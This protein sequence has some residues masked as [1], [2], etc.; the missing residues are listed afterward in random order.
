MTTFF[1]GYQRV[2]LIMLQLVTRNSGKMHQQKRSRF[3]R[4]WL[5]R[6]LIA[7]L[8][9]K[10]LDIRTYVL[11]AL[12]KVGDE[13]AL[14]VIL[15]AAKDSNSTI[16]RYAVSALADMGDIRATDT[17]I[18]ALGDS[19]TDIRVEAVMALGK[20]RDKRA[21]SVLIALLDDA[22]MSVRAQAV[23]SLGHIGSE[24]ALPLLN[25]M[26][27]NESGE[28]MRRYISEAIREIEGGYCS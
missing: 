2:D 17:L 16:R 20:L 18:E 26:M 13:S 21:D 6:W 25:R 9:V 7:Q 14:P 23:I 3:W 24:R 10:S 28:W 12:G 22:D 4:R 1:E 11:Q 27:E 5:T 8:R 15:N 19:E